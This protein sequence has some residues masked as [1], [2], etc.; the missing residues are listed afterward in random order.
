MDQ[1]RRFIE[2]S[3]LR[4]R[5]E[6]RVVTCRQRLRNGDL[7]STEGRSLKQELANCQA[8]L[9]DFVTRLDLY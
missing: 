6:D 7:N 9:N 8:V 2:T 5:L 4:D 3:I 1:W